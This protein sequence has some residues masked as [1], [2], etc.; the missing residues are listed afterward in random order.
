MDYLSSPLTKLMSPILRKKRQ[1]DPSSIKP[2][3][4]RIIRNESLVSTRFFFQGS[5]Q[6]TK[7][8]G[9]ITDQLSSNENETIHNIRSR[10][11]LIQDT[12]EYASNKI[13]VKKL[14]VGDPVLPRHVD[15]YTKIISFPESM[16][17]AS[18]SLYNFIKKF[19]FSEINS[20]E[21]H[22]YLRASNLS[23]LLDYSYVL[24]PVQEIG[25]SLIL[26]DNKK[27]VIEFYT[28][29]PD[30]DFRIPCEKVEKVMNN[31]EKVQNYEWQEI[32]VPQHANLSDS[33]IFMLSFIKDLAEDNEFSIN[34]E[35]VKEFREQIIT[36][37]NNLEE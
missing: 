27:E 21:Y 13:K 6:S 34:R 25:W 4:I 32:K 30:V 28:S 33:G 1:R 29:D 10:L 3:K 15:K 26:I 18:S 24:L 23:S 14:K 5:K 37:L 19:F 11:R 35:N 36:E 17:C 7:T 20:R 12:I 8:E 16:H 9:T 31:L 22:T 2:A